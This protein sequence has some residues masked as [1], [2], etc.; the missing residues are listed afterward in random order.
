MGSQRVGHDEQLITEQKL[1]YVHRVILSLELGKFNGKIP[2]I[3]GH[4]YKRRITR[5]SG[6]HRWENYFP[7][8]LIG[9]HGYPEYAGLLYSGTRKITPGSMA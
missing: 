1:C 4:S 6:S 3:T 9:Q 8:S 2:G 5:L 7:P